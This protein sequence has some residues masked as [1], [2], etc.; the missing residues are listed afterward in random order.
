MFGLGVNVPALIAQIIML[1]L[2]VALIV[3]GFR[4]RNRYLNNR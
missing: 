1:A 4:L 2:L 3:F